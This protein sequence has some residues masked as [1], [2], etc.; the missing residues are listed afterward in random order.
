M[1]VLNDPNL[2]SCIEDGDLRQF[3]EQRFIDM[4]GDD[5]YDPD[6]NGYMIIVEAGD[7][8]PAL[9]AASG[10]LIL[11]NVPGFAPCF[12]VLEEHAGFYEMVFVPSDGD[13]GIVIFIPKSAGI[14]ADLRAMCAQYCVPAP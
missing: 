1:L 6:L 11:G 3:V 4:C 8:V 2:S 12:E 7:T 13:F 10:C 9:E 5:D 14:N